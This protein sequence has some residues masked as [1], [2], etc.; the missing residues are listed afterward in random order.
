ML[1]PTFL[2][3][4]HRRL[5]DSLP[6]LFPLLPQGAFRGIETEKWVPLSLAS[7]GAPE[8]SLQATVGFQVVSPQDGVSA[9]ERMWH[10]AGG[11]T[12]AYDKHGSFVYMAFHTQEP[13]NVG[14]FFRSLLESS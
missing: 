8:Q 1:R 12:Q 7:G 13:Q 3:S 6:F 11:D 4:K 5:S 14:R 9:K 2:F 10:V